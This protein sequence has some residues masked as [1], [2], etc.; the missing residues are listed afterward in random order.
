[1]SADR[2]SP[3]SWRDCDFHIHTYHS[4]CGTAEMIPEAI[5]R[6]AHAIGLKAIALTDHLEL[7]HH[8][9]YFPIL[10]KE[11]RRLK[12]PIPVAYGCEA[13]VLP[14]RRVT[15]DAEFAAQ[16]D[17]ILCGYNH[18]HNIEHVEHF[19]D[20]CDAE[21]KAEI[22]GMFQAAVDCPLI[23]AIAHPFFVYHGSAMRRDIYEGI[24]E[25]EIAPILEAA[26]RNDIAFEI[27]PKAIDADL[28]PAA[29]RLYRLAAD[30]GLSFI[31]GSDSHILASLGKLGMLSDF[32]ESLGLDDSRFVYPAPK[33]G[34][35]S[36]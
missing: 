36:R 16:F 7:D 23:D 31:V 25:K 9:D 34:N 22:L 33:P 32:I 18:F 6:R 17:H 27:S 15:I 12:S 4:E 11:L 5:V 30:A 28:K 21:K 13:T 20:L 10:R 19:Y 14:P 8:R 1:M 2:R 26:L 35:C 24:T 29:D 3:L